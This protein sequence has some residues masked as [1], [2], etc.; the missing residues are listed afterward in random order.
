MSSRI[1]A[2]GELEDGT[3]WAALPVKIA[4]RIQLERTAH[5][6]KWT[7][8]THSMTYGAFLSWHASKA[9]GKHDL[10]WDDFVDVALEAGVDGDEDEGDPETTP[11]GTASS[12]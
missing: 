1:F 5:V 10:K 8:E 3:T 11:T 2:Y 12:A 9:A 4:S 7:A 6:Q